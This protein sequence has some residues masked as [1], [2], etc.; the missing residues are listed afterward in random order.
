MRTITE[1]NDFTFKDLVISYVLHVS[2]DEKFSMQLLRARKSP[3]VPPFPF[4]DDIL[5]D[6]YGV[7]VF[8]EQLMEI[9]Q[10]IGG[11]SPE[12]SNDL[13]RLMAKKYRDGV[14]ER[15]PAF[16]RH[17]IENGYAETQANALYDLL[18]NQA[19]NLC[20]RRNVEIYMAQWLKDE[21]E[22]LLQ[23]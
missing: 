3:V 4:L 20:G 6:I 1:A 2:S 12:E 5:H 15:R 10:R 21:Y 16:V 18:S 9:A 8:Q 23:S 7:L 17:A 13:R 11:F 19:S 22:R 14:E